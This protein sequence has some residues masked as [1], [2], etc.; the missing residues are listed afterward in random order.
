MSEFNDIFTSTTKEP[1]Q[2]KGQ[3]ASVENSFNKEEW[4]AKKKEERE[5]VY[6]MTD[7][8]AVKV[9]ADPAKFQ[10][11]LDTQSRFDR[12]T[13]TNA[14]L[15]MEQKPEATQIGA[16][17]YWK[18]N[19]IY[20]KKGEMQNPIFIL[21][22]GN[23]YKREDGSV[24]ISYNVKRLYDVSQSEGNPP[25]QN[26]SYNDKLVIK[27]LKEAS[28]V[29]VVVVEFLPDDRGALYDHNSQKIQ[30]RL[31]GMSAG[32]IF[33]AFS[34]EVAMAEMCSSGNPPPNASFKAYAASYALCKK[35]GIDV[36]SYKFDQS[37]TVLGGIEPH[38]V[39]GELSDIRNVV[40]DIN[41]RMYKTLE[42]SRNN[43]EQEA[44]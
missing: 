30:V 20:I 33:R 9:A 13:A 18:K 7:N 26:K 19:K 10:Q 28:P 32:D 37:G 6:T 35:Y 12:Y 3:E 42:Q 40:A 24:G 34:Q 16:L 5:T 38:E 15:I 29:N 41:G 14:L 17:D 31:S 43:K 44:R 25:K 11:Y 36:S 39:R 21:E 8:A 2:Q 4:A 23:E 27:A 22:P 1:G